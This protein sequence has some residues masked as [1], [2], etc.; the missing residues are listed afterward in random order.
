M[1]GRVAPCRRHGTVY[2]ILLY[3]YASTTISDCIRHPKCQR[4]MQCTGRLWQANQACRLP[5]SRRQFYSRQVTIYISTLTAAQERQAKG[6][7]QPTQ[8]HQTV[9]TQS[10]NFAD[11]ITRRYCRGHRYRCGGGRTHCWCCLVAQLVGNGVSAR[12]HC[13]R[14]GYRSG[15]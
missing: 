6:R 15:C 2:N 11:S 13:S 8:Q 14:G 10:W 5:L 4:P 9:F 7:E 12:R 1:A 3:R